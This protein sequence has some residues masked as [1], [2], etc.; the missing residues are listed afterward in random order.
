MRCEKHPSG[1]AER[2]YKHPGGSCNLNVLPKETAAC[3][4]GGELNKWLSGS[5]SAAT[6]PKP[7]LPN[8]FSSVASY[9]L[10]SPFPS[11]RQDVIESLNNSLSLVI[12]LPQNN[13]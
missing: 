4:H 3:G 13:L 12:T 2:L 6:A 9:K 11:T 5:K 1:P 10:E 8:N 7:P